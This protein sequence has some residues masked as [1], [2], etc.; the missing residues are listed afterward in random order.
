MQ[1]KIGDQVRWRHAV[2]DLKARDALGTITAVLPN[3]TGVDD[4]ALYEIEF[5]FG[6]FILY[7]GQIQ[8]EP[9]TIWQKL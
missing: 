7:G 5:D 8:Q 6:A 1:F 2:R 9:D 3:E 4:F